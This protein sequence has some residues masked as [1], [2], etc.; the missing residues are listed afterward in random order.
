MLKL[1]GIIA[2]CNCTQQSSIYI[3]SGKPSEFQA[4]KM[5]KTLSNFNSPSPKYASVCSFIYVSF[6]ECICN[7]LSLKVS[8]IYIAYYWYSWFLHVQVRQDSAQ[9]ESPCIFW[10]FLI[11]WQLSK[12]RQIL[13]GFV[14]VLFL[15]T[16]D[17]L[18]L[19]LLLLV[20]N[21]MNCQ[22]QYDLAAIS[23]GKVHMFFL[24]MFPVNGT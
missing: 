16:I 15:L 19:N 17:L 12:L 14:F 2:N 1:P 11:Q 23:F 7:I 13:C 24:A 10:D 8:I 21:S 9:A 3:V 22:Y 6:F 5:K 18:L 20:W 4:T